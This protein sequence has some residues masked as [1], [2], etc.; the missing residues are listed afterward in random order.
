MFG[1]KDRSS[2]PTMDIDTLIGARTRIEGTIQFSGGLRIDGSVRGSLISEGDQQSVLMLSEKGVIEGEIRAPHVVINGTLKGDIIAS[3]R[4]ELAAH[5]R[6]TGNIYY[7]ILEM[8]AGAEV[9]GQIVRQEDPRKQLA[10][11]EVEEKIEATLEAKLEAR[12]EPKEKSKLEAKR[13]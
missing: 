10:K 3:E 1:S 13:A 12:I 9:C 4:V 5:A 2:R 6:V 7:K 11:P 8:A